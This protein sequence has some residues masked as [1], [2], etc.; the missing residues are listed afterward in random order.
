MGQLIDLSQPASA[1]DSVRLEA[2]GGHPCSTVIPLPSS[3]E[4]L[5]VGD[6]SPLLQLPSSC[7][8]LPKEP[9]FLLWPLCLL[10]S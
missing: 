8:P 9:C 3:G 10:L 2:F 5:R 7:A 4:A 6:Q 1:D